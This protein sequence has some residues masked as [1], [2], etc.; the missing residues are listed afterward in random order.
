M[1]KQIYTYIATYVVICA[2]QLCET[3]DNTI[4]ILI[5]HNI[6]LYNMCD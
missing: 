5:P 2:K 1:Y 4:L 3:C 6:S